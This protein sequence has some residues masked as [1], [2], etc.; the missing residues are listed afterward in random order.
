VARIPIPLLSKESLGL[1]VVVEKFNESM[2]AELYKPIQQK[3]NRHWAGTQFYN[4]VELPEEMKKKLKN[5]EHVRLYITSKALNSDFN[6]QQERMEPYWNAH[7]IAINHWYHVNGS[8]TGPTEAYYRFDI[9]LELTGLSLLFHFS[10]F[11]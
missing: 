11:I 6:V 4:T 2:A 3:W 1:V 5:G 8:A 10:F 7:G 9:W